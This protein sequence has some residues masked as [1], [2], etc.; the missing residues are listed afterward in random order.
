MEF[1]ETIARHKS[2]HSF[3]AKKVP[4]ELLDKITQAGNFAE[5]FEGSELHFTVITDRQLLDDYNENGKRLLVELP[6]SQVLKKRGLNSD[7]DFFD[8]APV[9]I[10]ISAPHTDSKTGERMN[11]ASAFCAAQNILSAADA[12]GLGGNL[13][14][15]VLTD[16]GFNM[17][18]AKVR[19]GVDGNDDVLA[20]LFIGYPAEDCADKPHP[21]PMNIRYCK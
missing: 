3:L 18:A 20:A 8:H 7:Y 13:S 4:E 10:L 9:V 15:A 11:N 17:P 14:L 6:T 19:T 16:L 12:L 21:H 5:R 1:F 2:V